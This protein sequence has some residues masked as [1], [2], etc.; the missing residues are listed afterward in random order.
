MSAARA[1]GKTAGIRREETVWASGDKVAERCTDASAAGKASRR[2]KR[3]SGMSRIAIRRPRTWRCREGRADLELVAE[4]GWCRRSK[5][6][7][8]EGVTARHRRAAV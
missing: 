7:A 2:K 6:G 3:S 4:R 8:L 5:R 1:M